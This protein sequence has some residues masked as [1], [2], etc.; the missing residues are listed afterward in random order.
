[1]KKAAK[2]RASALPE[3]PAR[4]VLYII[5]II[6][7]RNLKPSA[8]IGFLALGGRLNERLKASG[9]SERR[10]PGISNPGIARRLLAPFL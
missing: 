5:K 6:I 1:M 4:S 9:D 10:E 7:D 2:R 8:S 3:S